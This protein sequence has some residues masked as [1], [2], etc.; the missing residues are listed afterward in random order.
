M[1]VEVAIKMPISQ[2]Q[3]L[4]TTLSTSTINDPKSI[5]VYIC[6]SDYYE[7]YSTSQA[8]DFIPKIMVI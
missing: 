4:R 2:Y 6:M 1:L 3:W 8:F 7:L 5:I